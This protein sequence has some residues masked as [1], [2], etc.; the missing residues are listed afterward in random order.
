MKQG[1]YLDTPI[2]RLIIEE[3]GQAITGV[4][5]QRKEQLSLTG[6]DEIYTENPP[7]NLL[8]EAKR[9]LE[10]YFEGKRK[11]FDLPINPQGTEFQK[12]VYKA[13]CNI[14]YGETKSY[15]EIAAL[16]G[17]PK[18]VRAVGGANNKNPMLLLI[19]CHRVVGADGRLTGFACGLEVK[20]YLLKLEEEYYG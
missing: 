11:V 8:K 20:E 17:N 15:G 16:I 5:L 19:P 6:E 14:P 1:C 4:N 7:T 13:L 18:A 3:E 2:G 10:E 9:Q 12:K